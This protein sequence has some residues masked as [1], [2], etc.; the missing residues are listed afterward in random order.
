MKT[1]IKNAEVKKDVITINAMNHPSCVSEF[2]R[3][4][5]NCIEHKFKVI[6][7]D[8]KAQQFYPNACVPISGIIQYYQKKG[9][10]FLLSENVHQYIHTC[11]LLKPLSYTDEDDL[12]M[13][14]N[15]PLD[16]IFMFNSSQQV[17]KLSQSYVDTLST[18]GEFEPGV[19]DG[20][21][22]CINEVMDNVLTHSEKGEGYVMAQYH[23]RKSRVAF[24]VYD[25]G[26]G[27]Y[28]TLKN[29]QHRPQ[30]E[31][32]ALTLAIQEGVGDG[33]GQG[34]GLFGLYKSV[35]SNQGIL[36]LTSGGAS[37]ILT[38]DG[39]TKKF[40]NVPYLSEDSKQTIVDFQINIGKRIDLK[41]IF[42]SISDDY[43][44]YDHR[45]DEMLSDE[46]EFLHYDV[47]LHSQGTGTREAGR[48]LRNDVINTL[49]REKRPVVLDFS[50]VKLVSSSFIDEFIAKLTI[51]LGFVNFNK[52]V[53]LKEMTEKVSFF[54]N[55]S[56]YMRIAEE[57][58]YREPTDIM[59]NGLGF[60]LSEVIERNE[61]NIVESEQ[62]DQEQ[63]TMVDDY[64]YFSLKENNAFPQREDMEARNRISQNQVIE[65]VYRPQVGE[66]YYMEDIVYDKQKKRL[67][68]VLRFSGC[69]YDV[70][71]PH[72]SKI[73][74]EKMANKEKLQVTIVQENQKSYVAK[75]K[76]LV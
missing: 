72:F 30:N 38:E 6:S 9:M 46:D 1:N 71:V 59:A 64:S 39:N 53:R 60:R 76:T 15:H 58:G 65:E 14:Y 67:K 8:V 4:V 13:A 52:L 28:N 11:H 10:G 49:K 36:S 48:L 74:Y 45:I 66:N 37:V 18:T 24:C 47:Y 25:S 34:N 17:A 69:N 57:W 63:K 7:I 44:F 32:D 75:I 26:I 20:I 51:R 3:C 33:K 35:L 54:C 2:I 22:W 61:I 12:S 50:G 55:R 41:S 21:S 62:I 19:L 23:H 43:E 27:I 70:I 29:S 42:S 5:N 16:K 56:L 31:I 73:S 68:G 40:D